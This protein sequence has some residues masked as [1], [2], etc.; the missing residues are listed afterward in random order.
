MLSHSLVSIADLDAADITGLIDTAVSLK[1]RGPIKDFAGKTLALLFEKPSLRTKVSFDVAMYQLGGHTVFMSDKEVG[2]G[3]REPVRDAALVLSRYVDVISARTFAHKT[4]QDLA[5]YSTV[6]VI[7]ALSDEEH[8]CQAL[9]DLL[10]I[11]EH[12]GKLEGINLAYIGDGNNIAASLLLASALVGMNI[13]L[14]SPNGYEVDVAVQAKAKEYAAIS[15]S[16][17]VIT[18]DIRE[19]AAGADVLY[20]DVWASMGQ[21]SESEKRKKDFA[22][23]QVNTGLFA[24]AAGDAILMHD[25]PAHHGDE[26]EHGI[27]YGERSVVF[28]QAENRMHAQKAVLYKL[29]NT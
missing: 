5:K 18:N 8:P 11:H 25:L 13:N 4:V 6:P 19:V 29:I 17:I 14:A 10:T 12:K 27:I 23:Y 2:L 15:G 22:G 9:A 28:D 20:T 21:E 3:Q 24:I 1:K 16:K 26:V 7:N